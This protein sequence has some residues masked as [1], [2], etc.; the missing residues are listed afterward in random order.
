[1]F[2]IK[3]N[4]HQLHGRSKTIYDIA[5]LKTHDQT[6]TEWKNEWRLLIVK[7]FIYWGFGLKNV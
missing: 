5:K 4:D 6:L 3:L 7:Q 1:M 2:T